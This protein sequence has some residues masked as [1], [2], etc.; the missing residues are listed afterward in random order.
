M[1]ADPVCDICQHRKT[2]GRC[3]RL[4]CP[5]NGARESF[6]AARPGETHAEAT[7]EEARLL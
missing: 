5:S 7:K 6:A 2:L 1:A 4:T 3:W